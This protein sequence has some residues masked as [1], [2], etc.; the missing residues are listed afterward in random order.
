M[1]IAAWQS[2]TVPAPVQARRSPVRLR[3]ILWLAAT[4]V[5][6]FA[7]VR[8]TSVLERVA[9][10]HPGTTNYATP[11]GIEEVEFA[12]PDGKT[13]HAWFMPA[14]NRTEG[15]GPAPAILHCHGNE[16]D[17]AAH[18]STSAYIPGA[19]IS[20][21]LFDYRGFGKSTPCTMLTRDE[22]MTDAEA[23]YAYL[24]TRKDVDQ[25]RIGAFGYSLGGV[26]ALQLAAR[27]PEIKC[28][29]S[30]AAFCSWPSVASDFAPVLG[31]ILIPSGLAAEDAAALLGNRPLLLVHGDKDEIVGYSHGQRL[32]AVATAAKVPAELLTV[33]GGKHLNI[34]K[35]EVKQ[36]IREFFAAKLDGTH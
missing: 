22:L 34:F 25:S 18:A 27:H 1:S 17:I 8:W 24:K 9:F 20:V 28:V 10:F 32:L 30:V 31:R 35:P 2:V 33:V 12:T 5:V 15:S 29:G 21:L 11:P 7:A 16:G 26:Y 4:L 13:L 23:A 36:R 14:K 6:V 19:G 3:F